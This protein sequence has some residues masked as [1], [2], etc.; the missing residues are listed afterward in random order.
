MTDSAL[1]DLPSYSCLITVDPATKS[2]LFFWLIPSILSPATAPLI[3]WLQ[4]GPGWPSMYGLFK[5]NGPFL[6]EV[7]PGPKVQRVPNRHSWTNFA[8]MLYID[9][10]VGTGFSFTDQDEGYP[11]TDLEVI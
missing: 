9:N 11:T 2:N 6:L 4:G 10:P 8:N 7:T 5:E 1:G 3:L